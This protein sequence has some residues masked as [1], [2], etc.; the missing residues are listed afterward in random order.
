MYYF[1][2]FYF[3]DDYNCR[4]WVVNTSASYSGGPGFKSRLRRPAIL[5]EIIHGFPQSLQAN[6]GM[7]P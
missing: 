7:V 3:L 2:V 6:A 4:S 5:I 1:Y